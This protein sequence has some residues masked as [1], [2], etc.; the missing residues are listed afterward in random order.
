MYVVFPPPFGNKIP[1]W[2]VI[3]TNRNCENIQSFQGVWAIKNAHASLCVDD[4]NKS[5]VRHTEDSLVDPSPTR[6]NSA[7]V[8]PISS[9]S[10]IYPYFYTVEST[11]TPQFIHRPFYNRCRNKKKLIF[12]IA[13]LSIHDW[14]WKT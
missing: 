10:T 13:I 1:I 2:E 3:Y 14:Q 8:C 9:T 6:K 7:F 5:L 11:Y 12:K 4:M